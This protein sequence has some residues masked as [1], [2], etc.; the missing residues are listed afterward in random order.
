MSEKTETQ[1]KKCDLENLASIF[2]SLPEGDKREVLGYIKCLRDRLQLYTPR[3]GG[4]E[5]V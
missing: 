4:K 1:E 3:E 5:A 2:Q